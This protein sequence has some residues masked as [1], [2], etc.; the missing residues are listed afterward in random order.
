MPAFDSSSLID[1]LATRNKRATSTLLLLSF[2]PKFAD[3]KDRIDYALGIA[4]QVGAQIDLRPLP[5]D[6]VF[7][8]IDEYQAQIDQ[9]VLTYKPLVEQYKINSPMIQFN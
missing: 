8:K 2:H 9:E 1:N 6:P 3:Q 4:R 5:I 7:S